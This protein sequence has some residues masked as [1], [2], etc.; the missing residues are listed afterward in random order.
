LILRRK[1][2][3]GGKSRHMPVALGAMPPA[4]CAEKNCPA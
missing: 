4:F 2:S 1:T 3:A